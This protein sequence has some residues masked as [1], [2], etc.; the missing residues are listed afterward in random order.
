[1]ELIHYF[2]LS[3]GHEL[4]FFGTFKIHI[5]GGS[6]I[7]SEIIKFMYCIFKLKNYII[8][9]TESRLKSSYWSCIC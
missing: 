6:Y 9:N 1:V 2:L 8:M 4:L 5:L 3:D 7:I